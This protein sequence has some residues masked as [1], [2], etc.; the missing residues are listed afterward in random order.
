MVKMS[1]CQDQK[2]IVVVWEDLSEWVEIRV[3]TQTTSAAVAKFL[4]ENIIT[5]HDVFN[6]LICNRDSENKLWIKNLINLYEI[7]HIIVLTYNFD[8][9]RMIEHEHKS[10]IDDLTKMTTEDLEK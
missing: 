5:Q 10:L 3:L 1:I 4:W 8:V 7:A 2:Y 6:K 9:N